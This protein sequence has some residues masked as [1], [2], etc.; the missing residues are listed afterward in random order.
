ML[1]PR[2]KSTMDR[3]QSLDN[4]DDDE[5]NGFVVPLK[6]HPHTA[7]LATAMFPGV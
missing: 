2:S 4:V 6:L 7:R 1:P 3:S 5:D